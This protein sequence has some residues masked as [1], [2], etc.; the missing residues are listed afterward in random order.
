MINWLVY[1][2]L[3]IGQIIIKKGATGDVA[4]IVKSKSVASFFSRFFLS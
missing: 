4:K 1:N 2:N 3:K